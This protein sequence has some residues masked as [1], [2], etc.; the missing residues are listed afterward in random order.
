MA[1]AAYQQAAQSIYAPEEAADNAALAA[2]RD[3]TKN[4][5]EASKGDVQNTYQQ[6][7]DALT[8]STQDNAANINLLYSQ[9]LGGQFSGLQG[10]DLGG[11][12]AKA[13]QQQGYI[14]SERA[15]KLNQ[16][17]AGEANA[18]ID[19]NAGVNANT[20]KYQSEE[21]EYALNAYGADQKAQQDQS[22]A[23]RAYNLDVAKYK[24]S[25]A[26][27]NTAN[28]AQ[29]KQADM[30]TIAT[31]LQN[32]AGKDGHVSQETWNAAM[33][34]W[35]AAGYSAGDFVKNNMQYVNQ[36]YTG[37]HGYS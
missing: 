22:N 31:T 34:E 17:T 6:A 15:S 36:R 27:S 24:L 9:R 4:T 14:E 7:V 11:M 16:I 10:N 29:Q 12:F 33:S 37:Y 5:L 35:T 1:P 2:T 18:D 28:A 32:K 3:T 20:S 23:D 21:N 19:Y 25:A 30:G 8:Q 13:T 26:N